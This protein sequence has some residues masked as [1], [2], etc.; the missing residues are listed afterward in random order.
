M[1]GREVYRSIERTGIK[2]CTFGIVLGVRLR[3][4]KGT[5]NAVQNPRHA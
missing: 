2:K 3:R 5:N 1:Q 4:M